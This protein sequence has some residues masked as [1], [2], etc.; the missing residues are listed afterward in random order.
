M[1]LFQKL[2]ILHILLTLQIKNQLFYGNLG[3][4]STKK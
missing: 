2:Y 1:G 3:N 4:I